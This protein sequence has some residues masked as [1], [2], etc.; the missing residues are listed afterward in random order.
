[1]SK[2]LAL[3]GRSNDSI[4]QAWFAAAFES[5]AFMYS[6]L[7]AAATHMYALSQ[8]THYMILEYKSQAMTELNA[9]LADPVL[10]LADGN[11]GAVFNLLCVDEAFPL[12]TSDRD[13][14]DREV[15]Q[16]QRLVHLQGLKR[17]VALRGGLTSLNT[18][19]CLQSFLL[20]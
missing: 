2:A 12:P 10:C 5:R 14:M 4:Q 15:Q 6:I 8:T 11:I 3:G 20:W 7:C 13:A 19:P 16:M 17:M 18:S 9:A 1:M